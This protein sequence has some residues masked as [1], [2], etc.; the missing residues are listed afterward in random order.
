[1]DQTVIP[2]QQ[3]KKAQLPVGTEG[4]SVCPHKFRYDAQ[5]DAIVWGISNKGIFFWTLIALAGLS[6]GGGA[7]AMI[8]WGLLEGS[9]FPNRIVHVALVGLGFGGTALWILLKSARAEF[10]ITS[11]QIRTCGV[12]GLFEK[13]YTLADIDAVILKI[14]SLPMQGAVLEFEL[15]GQQKLSADFRAMLLKEESAALLN[16][17]FYLARRTDKPLVLKGKPVSACP[18]FL[19]LFIALTRLNDEE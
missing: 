1:M 3:L 8:V 15:F 17:A 10:A 5:N 2:V 18:E 19:N 12:F 11:G 14:D 7:L 9:G 16:L 13:V 6:F 4:F